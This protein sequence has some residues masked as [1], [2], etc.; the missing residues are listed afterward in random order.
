MSGFGSYNSWPFTFGGGESNEEICHQFLLDEYRKH[1]WDVEPGSLG[2]IEA[3]AEASLASQ[4]MEA[5]ER[6]GGQCV[7]ATMCESLPDWEEATGTLA[8]GS[9]AER[10]AVI[11]AK[12]L[13]YGGNAEPDIYNVCAA[14][15]GRQLVSVSYVSDAGDVTYW[16]GINPGP[17][18]LEWAT[19]RNIVLVRVTKV[20]VSEGVFRRLVSTMRALLDDFLPSR[21]DHSVYTHDTDSNGDDGFVVGKSLVGE[22]AP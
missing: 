13:G 21:M 19:T 9:P 5:A 17:P 6:G 20:G 15:L 14:L 18:G 10:R 2:E 7:P 11:K 4:V 3:Y 1:G 12:F 16:P 8:A 22:A